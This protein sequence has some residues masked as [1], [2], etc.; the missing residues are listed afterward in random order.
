ML[1]WYI[2]REACLYPIAFFAVLSRDMSSEISL[3]MSLEMSIQSNI[4]ND[5]SIDLF[6]PIEA[7]F[8]GENVPR[9]SII[10]IPRCARAIKWICR[11][12][13]STVCPGCT[14]LPGIG[15]GGF[16][17][18]T[19]YDLH[20][21]QERNSCSWRIHFRNFRFSKVSGSRQSRHN[22]VLGRPDTLLQPANVSAHKVSDGTDY[23]NFL[24]VDR[25]LERLAPGG[26]FPNLVAHILINRSVQ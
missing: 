18:V 14:R 19:M 6:D 4:G 25:T 17:A 1:H 2:R 22:H 10:Y 11:L 15:A 24:G 12:G 8:V 9:L 3:E 26:K 21:E 20:L 13:C 16:S 23:L 5:C 7:R